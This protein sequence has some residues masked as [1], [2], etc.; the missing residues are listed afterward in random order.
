METLPHTVASPPAPPAEVRRI[1]HVDMDAF[2][3]SVE[4]R[5]RPELQGL[6]VV[7]GGPP[8]SRSVVMAASYEA[9]KY[10]IRSAIP[11]SRAQRLCPDAVFIP[12]SFAKYRAVSQQIHAIF[13]RY[14]S[15]VEGLSLDEAF[16]DVT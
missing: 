8:A 12:P 2:Y 11:C 5:D 9:R 4:I 16:L 1:I 14:T 15:L 13:H 3:A 7:V 10:G 6:P